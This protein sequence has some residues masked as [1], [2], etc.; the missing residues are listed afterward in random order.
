MVSNPVKIR[1]GFLRVRSMLFSRI[2][3]FSHPSSS[4]RSDHFCQHAYDSCNRCSKCP[5]WTRNDDKVDKARVTQV[6][7]NE[8]NR[9]WEQTLLRLHESSN[10]NIAAESEVTVNVDELLN[11]GETEK[12]ES[13]RSRWL[14]R[15][16]R[17]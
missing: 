16:K 9:Q 11:A 5:L 14:R 2:H 12:K 3:L 7:I 4:R 17:R 8:A 1:H 13:R 10:N 15:L 6:A